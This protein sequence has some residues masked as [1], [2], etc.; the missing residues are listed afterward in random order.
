MR[1]NHD[2]GEG[3][4]VK[5]VQRCKAITRKTSDDMCCHLPP[6]WRVTYDGGE[7]IYCEIH[8][9]RREKDPAW[10]GVGHKWE[11]LSL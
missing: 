10:D 11:K 2:E 7:L 3:A 9:R 1:E 6:A 5:P 8:K 4:F